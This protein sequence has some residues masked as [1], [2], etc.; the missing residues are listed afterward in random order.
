MAS[1]VFDDAE[2]QLTLL[3]LKSLPKELTKQTRRFTQKL[4]KDE[5]QT[6]L[7]KRAATPLQRKVLVRSATVSVTNT[8]IRLKSATKGRMSNGTPTSELAKGAEFGADINVYSRYSRRSKRGGTHKVTRRV[9]RGFGHFRDGGRVVYPTTADLIPRLASM[10]T[11]T[12][13]RTTAEAFQ[14]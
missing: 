3:A 8:N 9:M 4:A 2:L 12:L 1:D 6:G 10:Y 13:L 7:E 11:Q 5:W 14:N